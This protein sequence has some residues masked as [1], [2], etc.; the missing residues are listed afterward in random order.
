MEAE[1]WPVFVFF[2]VRFVVLTLLDDLQR[3]NLA[4]LLSIP[5]PHLGE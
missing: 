2:D 1:S 5:K 4:T 3:V